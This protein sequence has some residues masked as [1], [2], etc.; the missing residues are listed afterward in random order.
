MIY[1]II[2]NIVG[3]LPQPYD[4]SDLSQSTKVMRNTFNDQNKQ[5]DNRFVKDPIKECDYIV[6]QVVPVDDQTELE[7]DFGIKDPGV[8]EDQFTLEFIDVKRS[9]QIFRA[10]YIPFLSGDRC[11]FN[12][13]TLYKNI[14]PKMRTKY[15]GRSKPK[16]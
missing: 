3:Q 15:L 6:D 12:N 9:P 7:P 4:I 16:S 5:N 11:K 8:W 2:S 14:S 1:T 10:F 13:Y